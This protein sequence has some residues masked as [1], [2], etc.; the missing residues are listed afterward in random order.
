MERVGLILPQMS[1]ELWKHQVSFQW[2]HLWTTGEGPEQ[3]RLEPLLGKRYVPPLADLFN[4]RNWASGREL[5]RAQADASFFH[6][7]KVD[8][9]LVDNEVSV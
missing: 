1:L 6:E 4:A 7:D 2:S 3:R 9:K 5:R 8:F